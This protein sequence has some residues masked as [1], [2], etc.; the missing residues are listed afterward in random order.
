MI[1]LV[2][3]KRRFTF[4]LL[5]TPD[6]DRNKPMR[7][8]LSRHITRYLLQSW[9]ERGWMER[10]W[11]DLF[12][13]YDNQKKWDSTLGEDVAYVSFVSFLVRILSGSGL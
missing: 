2:S 8:L 11:L 13:H 9:V 7:K 5:A 10:R 1:A 12:I 3:P 6:G 4:F